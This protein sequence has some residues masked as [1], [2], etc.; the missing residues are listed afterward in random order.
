M[1]AQPAHPPPS[2]IPCAHC[3]LFL[4]P[5]PLD[6]REV[7][8]ELK[9]KDKWEEVS[10]WSQCSSFPI[11]VPQGGWH[12]KPS[13]G[14][15]LSLLWQLGIANTTYDK[16]ESEMIINDEFSTPLII[17]IVT[18]AGSLLLIAAIYG[19]CHQRFSQKKDQVRWERGVGQVPRDL[20][21]LR[22]AFGR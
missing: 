20:F 14:P 9:E 12:Q 6:P 16:M 4:P 11:D 22:G 15:D 18:L 17:T 21:C 7:L 8:E 3:S 13:L 5:V 2:P 1:V 19:C 10:P